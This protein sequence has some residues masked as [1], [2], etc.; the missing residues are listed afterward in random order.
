VMDEKGTGSLL[1]SPCAEA[2]QPA[3]FMPAERVMLKPWKPASPG[4]ACI[5][6]VRPHLF[7]R[8]MQRSIKRNAERL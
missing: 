2:K 1:G 3:C 8:M 7:T 5:E 4:F 6:G